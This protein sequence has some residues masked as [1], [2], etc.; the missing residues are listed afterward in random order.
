MI[1]VNNSKIGK[2]FPFRVFCQKVI[3]LAFDESMSY[4]ELLYS[5]LH[6]LK[7]TVIP[8]VNNNADAVTELQNLY[9]ELKSFVDNYFENL[10]IQ[11]EINS[12]LD[13]MASSGQLADLVS[14][15]LQ[16]QAIIG[17][18][19][20]NDLKNATNLGNNSIAK[21]L[22]DLT[23]ND[24]KGAFYKV[25][26]RMNSDVPDG[27]NLI[28]LD[29]TENLVAEII[30]DYFRNNLQSQIDDINEELENQDS[31]FLGDSYAA[32]TTY[33]H[34]SVEYLTS[35]CEYLR[36]LM[37]LTAGHYYIF[38]QGNAGFAKIGNN[39]MNFQMALASHINEIADRNKIKNIFVCAGYNDYTEETS[40]IHQR[41][42]EFI[43]YCKQQFPN[44][45]VY[46]GMIGGN[47]F[48]D[49][50][51]ALARE[52]LITKV[53][54]AYIR[55]SDFG[56]VYLSGVELFTHNFYMFNRQGNHPNEG[57]YQR[58]ATMIY[59]AWKQGKA[60]QVEPLIGVDIPGIYGGN[61]SFQSTMQ[62][63]TKIIYMSD[64]LISGQT[65][66]TQG[67]DK[68][69]LT[70]AYPNNDLFKS[71]ISDKSIQFPCDLYIVDTNNNHHFVPA[72]VV[73]EVD[74]SIAVQCT[75]FAVENPVIK[76]LVIWSTTINVPLLYS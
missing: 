30:P 55:C 26:T 14:Q 17:F 59:N 39:S 65:I 62:N 41:I 53:L 68:I 75:F 71:T 73:V 63:Y 56:G 49:A 69:K 19:T 35:W 47:T 36:Q 18:Q 23:V 50:N 51:G 60:E 52:Q 6:Y 16:S 22:G 9:N 7:E 10:D 4:L 45:Q 37:G 40:L 3:P 32:G 8:A 20:S 72:K 38:A 46:L 15:Y 5:L 33:E 74:G 24:G 70:N 43:E 57:G 34:G 29:N 58:V 31:I 42:G 54:N 1:D 61:M 13:E 12:K 28:S 64:Y 76:D 48:D 67:I 11:E 25:R 27:Y 21:T 66:N 2:P 44:A